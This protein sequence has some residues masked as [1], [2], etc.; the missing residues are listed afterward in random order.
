MTANIIR[1]GT[2]TGWGKVSA[3][4]LLSGERFYLMSTGECVSLLSESVVVVSLA[5]G[6]GR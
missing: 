1:L 6:A 5:K 2:M 4:M 3:V